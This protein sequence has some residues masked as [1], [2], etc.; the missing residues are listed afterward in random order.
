[1]QSQLSVFFKLPQVSDE[2]TERPEH[3]LH[4]QETMLVEWLTEHAAQPAT[5]TVKPKKAKAASE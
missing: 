2:A 4:K 1:M 3:A 5:R